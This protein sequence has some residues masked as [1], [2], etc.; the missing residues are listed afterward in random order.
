[1]LMSARAFS[2]VVADNQ[3]AALGIMLLG[4]LARIRTT[5]APLRKDEEKGGDMEDSEIKT[6]QIAGLEDLG[7][8]VS[9][10]EVKR[11]SERGDEVA[12][13]DGQDSI[14]EKKPKKKRSDSHKQVLGSTPSKRPN[15]RRKRVDAFDD[16][17]DKLI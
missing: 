2:A 3:Y 13:E 5:I 12:S 4:T 15:K 1:M 10:E 6:S 17:F 8:A 9:R 11:I 7:V 16:L 14:E